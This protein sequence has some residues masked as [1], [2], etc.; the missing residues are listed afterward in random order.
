MKCIFSVWY[1]H[2]YAF[3]P[4]NDNQWNKAFPDWHLCPKRN[5]LYLERLKTMTY[6]DEEKFKRTAS[7]EP[8][9]NYVKYLEEFLTEYVNSLKLMRKQSI[10]FMCRVWCHRIKHVKENIG[11][12]V[13]EDALRGRKKSLHSN[14]GVIQCGKLFA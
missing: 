11:D 2:V 9:Y 8:Y 14:V 13:E 5:G 1:Q 7:V 12:E 6:G 3:E 4:I 10:Y